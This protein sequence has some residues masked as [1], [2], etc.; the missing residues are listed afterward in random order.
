MTLY[1]TITVDTE[2]E[3]DWSSG[4][5]TTGYGVDN[6]QALPRFQDLCDRYGMAVTYFTAYSVIYDAAARKVMQELAARPNVEIGLHIHPWNTPPLTSGPVRAR[7]SF[8]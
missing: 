3:W 6:I 8:L 1:C 2:E 5:P 7:D 4:F